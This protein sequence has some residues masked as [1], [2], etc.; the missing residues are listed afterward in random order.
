MSDPPM[1]EGADH[2]IVIAVGPLLSSISTPVAVTPVGGPGASG[3]T[4]RPWAVSDQSPRSTSLR[5]ATR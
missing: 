3:C 2:V 5:A 1:S 4:A